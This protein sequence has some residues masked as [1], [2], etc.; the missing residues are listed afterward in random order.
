MIV[1]LLIALGLGGH[2]VDLVSHAFQGG[3]EGGRGGGHAV[4]GGEVVVNEE[5]DPHGTHL[6]PREG[7]TSNWPMRGGSSGNNDAG[8]NMG[9]RRPHG[10]GDG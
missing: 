2:H 3:A 5:G 9:M 1:G 4:D 7:C 10:T 8:G 6:I